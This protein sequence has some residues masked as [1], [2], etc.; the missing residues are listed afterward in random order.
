MFRGNQAETCSISC[1]C[2]Q[3]FPLPCPSTPPHSV[4]EKFGPLHQ[5]WVPSLL[6]FPILPS[7]I[8]SLSS[9][10]NIS[11][12]LFAL[13]IKFL[14]LNWA[15]FRFQLFSQSSCLSFFEKVV[16]PP[17]VLA[18]TTHP[19]NSHVS[20]SPAQI[21]FPDI[22]P[23]HPIII[24]VGSKQFILP[25]SYPLATSLLPVECWFSNSTSAFCCLSSVFPPHLAKIHFPLCLVLI[26]TSL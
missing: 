4:S 18:S 16:Q 12:L 13:S 26:K 25:Y 9:A 21:S 1:L 15:V 8:Y 19:I 11:C 14:Q 5:L 7:I 2:L 23:K 6:F 24:T 17:T 3:R 10:F 20:T 22:S